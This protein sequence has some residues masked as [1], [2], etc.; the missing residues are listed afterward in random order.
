MQLHAALAASGMST[1]GV[2]SEIGAAWT[3]ALEIAESL[4]NAE[5]QLRAL[6]GLWSFRISG[7]QHCVALTLAQKF[8]TVA[9]KR[10]DPNDRLV[11]DRPLRAHRRR[12]AQCRVAAH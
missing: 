10:S 6:W 5:Y 2:V 7:G 11:G 1:R 8:H 4:D 9:A 3:P 12:L